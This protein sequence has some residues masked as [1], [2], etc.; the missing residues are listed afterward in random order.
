MADEERARLSRE[1]EAFK[2]ELHQFAE[3]RRDALIRK[4]DMYARIA[5]SM[6]VFLASS[7]RPATVFRPPSV[8]TPSRKES[9][10][11][12]QPPLPGIA[13]FH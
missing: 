9:E 11:P 8:G 6:R 3:E 4:R 1:L 7:A 2:N 12:L 10:C 13:C 5:T